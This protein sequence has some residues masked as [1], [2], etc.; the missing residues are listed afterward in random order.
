VGATCAQEP[1]AISSRLHD[2]EVVPFNAIGALND[3]WRVHVFGCNH[4]TVTCAV[5]VTDPSVAV[6]VE[7]PLAKPDTSPVWYP[8][9]AAVGFED[10]QFTKVVKS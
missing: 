2:G 9:V 1:M 3:S 4:G 10:D 5:L 7:A 6:M 8:I